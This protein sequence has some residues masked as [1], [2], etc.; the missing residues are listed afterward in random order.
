MTRR[1]A[2]RAGTKRRIA[3]LLCLI[4]SVLYAS[5]VAE[6][7]QDESVVTKVKEP[8][9]EQ[10]ESIGTGP[11]ETIL[12]R[13]IRTS[14]ASTKDERIRDFNDLQDPNR[15]DPIE[16]SMLDPL[17]SDP[18]CLEG[19]AD[20]WEPPESTIE[21]EVKIDA[22]CS[23]GGDDPSEEVCT[24]TQVEVDKHW[25]SDARILRMRDQLRNAGSGSSEA[26]RN[27]RP[28]IFLLPGL[29]STRL[30]AWR[31]KKCPS[32]PLLSDI[33]IQDYV[34]L[35]INLV[36]QMGTIDVACMKECMKLG[37]NQSDTDDLSV[38]CKLRYVSLFY[39]CFDVK[40]T[41]NCCLFHSK[42]S[43]CCHLTTFNALIGTALMK[44]WMPS[45]LLPLAGL[46]VN[47]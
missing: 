43:L 14:D 17:A 30:V 27:R 22:T 20:C 11:S 38:G 32:H 34:W 40:N 31:H 26:G 29:A 42:F 21:T 25:G 44:V 10:E 9:S 16:D 36:I 7:N 39:F 41:L 33:K 2:R 47:F 6:E 28:P 24:P 1:G 18:S 15:E 8:V 46:A 12:I 19:G 3:L 13:R 4:T 23:Y 37:T 5:N 45:R 35:N